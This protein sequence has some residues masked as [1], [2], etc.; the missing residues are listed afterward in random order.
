MQVPCCSFDTD[1]HFALRAP[2]DGEGLARECEALAADQPQ[3]AEQTGYWLGRWIADGLIS[4]LRE[5]DQA[6]GMPS[7][8]DQA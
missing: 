4:G 3:A 8:S 1:E 2:L 6:P 7:P 5:P